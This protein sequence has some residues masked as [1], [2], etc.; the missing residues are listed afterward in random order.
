MK[1]LITLFV[2]VGFCMAALGCP[3]AETPKPPPPA[4]TG[5]NGDVM[6]NDDP[7]AD[8]TIPEGEPP[9]LNLPLEDGPSPTPPA[10]NGTDDLKIDL[11][12]NP[13]K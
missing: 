8:P 6:P 4:T 1:K 12:L 11:D 3:P 7:N 9:P 2:L 13:G 10:K 5:D